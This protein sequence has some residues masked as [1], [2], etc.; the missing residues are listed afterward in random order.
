MFADFI[1]PAGAAIARRYREDFEPSVNRET[2]YVVVCAT[3]ICAETDEEAEA[4]GVEQP[5]GRYVQRRTGHPGPLQP[6]EIAQ[7]FLVENGG[8]SQSNLGGRRLIVGSPS[9]VRA[10]IEAVAADYGADEMLILTNTHSHEARK[11]SYELIAGAF[12]LS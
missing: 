5:D 3:A 9:T 2:P 11:R 12:D 1:N 4:S 10:G 8:W 6:V 7:K